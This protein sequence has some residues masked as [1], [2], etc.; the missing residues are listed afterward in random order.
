MNWE[1]MLGMMG[2]TWLQRKC[3]KSGGIVCVIAGVLIGIA[4]GVAGSE[5]VAP[6]SVGGVPAVECGSGIECK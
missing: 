6:P 1:R 4:G 5:Y 3:E 2:I